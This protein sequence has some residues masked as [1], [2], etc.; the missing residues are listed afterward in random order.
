LTTSSSGYAGGSTNEPK[1]P[2]IRRLRN[3]AIA[4]DPHL[5]AI[6]IERF[7]RIHVAL[8]RELAADTDQRPEAVAP[9]MIGAAAVAM[10]DVLARLAS[11]VQPEQ[12]LTE[13]DR[14]LRVLRGALGALDT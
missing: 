6:R 4:S 2:E 13:L 14:N 5:R 8:A 7:N 10:L 9:Q 1:D 11:D 3:R 12:A